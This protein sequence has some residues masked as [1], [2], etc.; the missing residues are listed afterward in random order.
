MNKNTYDRVT[1][2]QINPPEERARKRACGRKVLEACADLM[3]LEETSGNLILVVKRD[4]MTQDVNLINGAFS[5]ACKVPSRLKFDCGVSLRTVMQ[6]DFP[7]KALVLQDAIG[8]LRSRIANTQILEDI[9][10]LEKVYSRAAI[11]AQISESYAKVV[12]Y[13]M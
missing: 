3:A 10:D 1:K 5:R 6:M 13:Y 11:G 12:N 4:V 7:F 8:I 2:M 9:F